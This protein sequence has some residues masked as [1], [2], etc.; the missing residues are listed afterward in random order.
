M[1]PPLVTKCKN[2]RRR[3]DQLTHYRKLERMYAAA[4]INTFFSPRLTVTEGRSEIIISVHISTGEMTA[5]GHIVH[6]TR[7]Q[8][9]AEAKLVDSEGQ[10]PRVR[11]LWKWGQAPFRTAEASAEALQSGFES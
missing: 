9:V 11:N 7:R 4:P 3:L 1:L 10:A 2:W 6:G 5:T 8:Y